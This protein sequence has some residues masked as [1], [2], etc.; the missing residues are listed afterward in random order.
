MTFEPNPMASSTQ[1]INDADLGGEN[2]PP[3]DFEEVRLFS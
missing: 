2:S 1:I 3:P